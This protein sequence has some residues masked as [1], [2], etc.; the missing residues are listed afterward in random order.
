MMLTR[1]RLAAVSVMGMLVIGAS[2]ASAGAVTA[3]VSPCSS[4]FDATGQGETA[5][6]TAEVCQGG[7]L[8]FIGP[9][10]GQIAA[11]TGP[12]IISPAVLGTVVVSA[13]NVVVAEGS[14]HPL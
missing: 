3:P 11:V 6:T 12:T 4:G 7:G 2:A 14:T 9:A 8:V 13:G 1:K 10:V 5:G